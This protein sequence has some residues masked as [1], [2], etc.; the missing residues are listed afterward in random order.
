MSG[1]LITF[2]HILRLK[3]E[4]EFTWGGGGAKQKASF[5]QIKHYLSTPPVLRA[6]KSG[7]PFQLYITAQEDVIGDVLM[8]EF[9]AKDHI[10]T[11]VS[12]R[13]LGAKTR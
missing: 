11:Y 4:T 3:D 5:D 1:K 12:R 9:G 10:I 13:L 6:P 8:Q 2:T 7:E